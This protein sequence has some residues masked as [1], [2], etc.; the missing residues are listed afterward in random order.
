MIKTYVVFSSRE[1]LLI[2]S[3]GSIRDT[4]ITDQL[5]RIGCSKFIAHE[6]PLE[7]VRRLYGD[8]LEVIERALRG[9][10]TFRVLDYS[11]KRVI[12][13]F[14]F[15]EFG[16]EIRSEM[17]QRRGEPGPRVSTYRPVDM[18]GLEEREYFN[19]G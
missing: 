19:G 1:P 7:H 8:R 15:S 18:K 13:S 17:R 3:R 2:V 4:K 9:N 14:P 5:H 12:R 16:S 6:V 11:G 10:A